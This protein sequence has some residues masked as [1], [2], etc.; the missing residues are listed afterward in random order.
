MTQ[1][2]VSQDSWPPIFVVVNIG[3]CWAWLFSTI[4]PFSSVLCLYSM[5]LPVV[6]ILSVA[7]CIWSLS[8]Q[9]VVNR[10][11]CLVPPDPCA[12][13][14]SS[15]WSGPVGSHRPDSAL[16][17]NAVASLFKLNYV[18][19]RELGYQL[20]PNILQKQGHPS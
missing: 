6:S 3:F 15:M 13:C 1:V 4:F 7:P 16:R 5:Y 10:I 18:G 2:I 17:T 19:Y 8:V 11:L 9:S 12:L 20:Y 14:H